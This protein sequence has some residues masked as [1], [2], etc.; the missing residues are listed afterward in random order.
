MSLTRRQLREME[1]TSEQ[2]EQIIL[3]HAETVEALKA[4]A[5]SAREEAHQLR[6]QL[7]MQSSAMEDAQTVQ[8]AFDAYKAQIE[9]TQSLQTKQ[10]LIRTALMEAGA[11]EQAA[12]LLLGAVDPQKAEVE[13][14]R[15]LN[16]DALLDSV[17]Q[18]HAA[19]FSEPAR[20]PLPVLQPPAS[21]YGALTKEDVSR[22]SA[23]E[24]NRNWHAVRSVLGRR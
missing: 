22:M 4:E 14:G 17:R 18:K 13:D 1:L 20:I 21:L 16:A 3:S 6:E 5:A 11:N 2:I 15:L 8:A 9:A 10:Q 7:D 24:I 23:E 19:F 12:E